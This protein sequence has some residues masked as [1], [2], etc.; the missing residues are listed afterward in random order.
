VVDRIPTT[1]RRW[2]MNKKLVPALGMV[3]GVSH[4]E[5]IKAL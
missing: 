2:L 4:G 1:P 3:R 5:Y